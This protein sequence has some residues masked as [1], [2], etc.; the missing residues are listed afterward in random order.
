MITYWRCIPCAWTSNTGAFCANC[1]RRREDATDAARWEK[2]F[3]VDAEIVEAEPCTHDHVER[4]D[5]GL[6]RKFFTCADC[7][8]E[9]VLSE[10]DED[11]QA[12]WEVP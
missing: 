11:G 6:D 5:D 10:V 7:G 2:F 3:T 9:V 12:Y 8:Q 4:D 1:G